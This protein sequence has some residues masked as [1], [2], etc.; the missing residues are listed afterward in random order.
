MTAPGQYAPWGSSTDGGEP[1]F[2]PRLRSTVARSNGRGCRWNPCR[3][4]ADREIPSRAHLPWEGATRLG[5]L[6]ATQRAAGKHTLRHRPA[7]PKSAGRHTP[8]HGQHPVSQKAAGRH[9]GTLAGVPS[10]GNSSCEEGRFLPLFPVGKTRSP[11]HVSLECGETR[12][13]LLPT[14]GGS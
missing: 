2:S 11:S 12:S 1:A 3:L 10:P 6:H 14:S 7:K 13:T 5:Q 9:V 8:R 4:D